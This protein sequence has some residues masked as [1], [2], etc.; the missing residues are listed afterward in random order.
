MFIV[1]R[2]GRA[3]QGSVTL[4]EKPAQS[5]SLF[6]GERHVMHASRSAQHF[7]IYQEWGAVTTRHLLFFFFPLLNILYRCQN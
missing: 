2:R 7:V 1:C 4:L 3:S 6:S 5:E